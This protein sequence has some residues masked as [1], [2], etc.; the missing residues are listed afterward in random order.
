M[1]NSLGGSLVDSSA[2]RLQTPLAKLL[3]T[4]KCC[5]I[6]LPPLRVVSPSHALMQCCQVNVEEPGHPVSLIL[7]VSAPPPRPEV[8]AQIVLPL[9]PPQAGVDMAIDANSDLAF[10]S[11]SFLGAGAFGQVCRRR[12]CTKPACHDGCGH[13]AD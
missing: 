3:A 5:F 1:F 6:C 2:T 13:T 11:N 4:S 7:M 9:D 10:P 8:L 12:D